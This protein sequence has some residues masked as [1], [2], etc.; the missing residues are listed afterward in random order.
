[1]ADQPGSW[2]FQDGPITFPV[3]SAVPKGALVMPDSTTPSSVKVATAGSTNVLGVAMKAA[4]PSTDATAHN[5]TDRAGV[6]PT[7]SVALSGVVRVTFASSANPGDMLVAAANGQV[8]KY[9][10][11]T[12]T[13]DQIV[14]TAMSVVSSGAVGWMEIE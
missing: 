5:A 13:Y 7:T 4:A 14:G 2:V 8:T 1:M 11:G 9:T 12:S 10:S 6:G 3:A